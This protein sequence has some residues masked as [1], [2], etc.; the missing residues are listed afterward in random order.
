MALG[1]Q[2]KTLSKGQVDAVLGYVG[3]TRHSVRNRVV[4][5]LEGYPAR[6]MK[7]P[8]NHP[9]KIPKGA[10]SYIPGAHRE[11]KL[12]RGSEP[13]ENLRQPWRHSSHTR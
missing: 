8:E 1:K 9:H 7:T 4:I 5:L 10:F 11:R 6:I 2:A 13:F 3:K 12:N